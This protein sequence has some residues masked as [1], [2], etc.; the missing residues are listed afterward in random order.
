[1]KDLCIL[2]NPAGN[3]RCRMKKWVQEINLPREYEKVRNVVQ[4][5]NFYK[6]SEMVLPQKDFWKNL[7]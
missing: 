1:M 5:V 7:L 6:Q 4:H 3:C 2:L